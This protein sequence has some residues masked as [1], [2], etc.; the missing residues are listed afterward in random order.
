MNYY[1]LSSRTAT[2]RPKLDQHSAFIICLSGCIYT[3]SKAPYNILIT[4][5]MRNRCKR[6][7]VQQT[8]LAPSCLHKKHLRAPSVHKECKDVSALHE[9]IRTLELILFNKL[10]FDSRAL[11]QPLP[12]HDVKKPDEDACTNASLNMS[13]QHAMHYERA[14]H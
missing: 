11:L 12:N 7:A 13:V 4:V 2:V 5:F 8:V 10:N 9:V 1:V 3:L 6:Y 14:S